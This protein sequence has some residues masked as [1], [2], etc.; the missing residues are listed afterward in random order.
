M[1]REWWNQGLNIQLDTRGVGLKK[2]LTTA[3]RLGFQIAMIL[4]DSEIELGNIAI[5]HL[6]TGLQETWNIQEVSTK[7]RQ[8]SDEST[9]Q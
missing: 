9:S 5:K 6:N 1:A 4:G 8:L 7:L 2:S 3:N